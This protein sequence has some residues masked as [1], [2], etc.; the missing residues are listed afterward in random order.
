MDPLNADEKRFQSKRWAMVDEQ[1]V[2]RGIRDE[3]I[4]EAFRRIPRHLFVPPDVQ[5]EAYA[6]HPIPIGHG[7]T[8]SQ[9]TMVGIMTQGLAL[10]SSDRVLEVG[11]GSG[12]QSAI[13]SLLVR[14]VYTIERIP[15]LAD[16]A[17]QHL[18][19]LGMQN[20]HG[21]CGDGTLGWKEE[22]PFQAIVVTAGAPTVP[23][24]L[25]DQL[26]EGGRLIIPVGTAAGQV[27]QRITKLSHRTRTE[28]LC[29]CIFVPLVGVEGW[30]A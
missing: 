3:R 15:D 2:P 27:L 23:A 29:S 4:L 26:A 21:T 24:S 14:D 1:L 20:V 12:Y 6:D 8:I 16:E 19:G 9:P 13:L 17:A 22:A 28:D 5:E 7:Q 30:T 18:A 10:G 25:V 11:T